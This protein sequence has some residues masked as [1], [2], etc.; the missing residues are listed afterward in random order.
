MCTIPTAAHVGRARN[1]H[2]LFDK[3]MTIDMMADVIMTVKLA[4][5][6]Y[7]TISYIILN[8]HLAQARRAQLGS[9]LDIVVLS[10]IQSP[11]TRTT[12]HTNATWAARPRE[13]LAQ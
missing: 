12:R 13:A 10:R 11:N 1:A 5:N 4:K 9:A 7:P 3:N 6:L 2:D 8:I